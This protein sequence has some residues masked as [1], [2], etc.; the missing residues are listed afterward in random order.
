MQNLSRIFVT[1]FGLNG[2]EIILRSKPS[3]PPSLPWEGNYGLSL[4]L[5]NLGY[6]RNLIFWT[7]WKCFRFIDNFE[8]SRFINEDD[9]HNGMDDENDGEGKFY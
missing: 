8:I 4:D 7:W 9:E 3:N 6:L 1:V 5:V 2:W